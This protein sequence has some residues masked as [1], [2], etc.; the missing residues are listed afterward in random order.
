MYEGEAS[1]TGGDFDTEI[2]SPFGISLGTDFAMNEFM[3]SF[4][5]MLLDVDDFGFVGSFGWKF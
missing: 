3:G 5:L 4:E 2:D 1:F